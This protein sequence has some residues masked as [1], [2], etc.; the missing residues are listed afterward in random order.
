[1][2]KYI[3]SLLSIC[4]VALTSTMGHAIEPVKVYTSV[5]PPIV[6]KDSV[7]PGY[8][9]ELVEEVLTLAN[10]EYEIIQMPWARA[11][12][13]VKSTPNT[14]I[15]PLT[16]TA[17]REK[18]YS[19]GFELFKTQTYFVTLNGE[20]LTAKDAYKKKIGVQLKSSWDN[21]LTEKGYNTISR[22][23]QEGFGIVRMMQVGRLDTW[24]AEGSVA[25]DILP[26]MG[27]SSATFSDPI[28]SFNTFIATNKN[29]PFTQM[30]KLK[31]AFKDIIS[32]GDYKKI[33]SKYN[34]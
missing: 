27:I 14:L 4:A 16:R 26:K 25:K 28:Q 19:W 24:Y 15:F 29:H 2:H 21:W 5:F 10:I 22:M 9:Y 33:M 20:K 23:P 8:A 7:R 13:L 31:A 17:T 11:Q 32:S 30:E 12:A 1:M 34:M 18:N 3:R 6:T